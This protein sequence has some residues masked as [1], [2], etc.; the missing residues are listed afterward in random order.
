MTLWWM[1]PGWT[2]ALCGQ[3]GQK[4]WPEGD[5]DHGVCYSCFM[6]NELAHE[7]QQQQESDERRRLENEEMERHYRDHPNG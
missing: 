3:C 7:Q 1:Q 2:D 5:P 4:I 6:A